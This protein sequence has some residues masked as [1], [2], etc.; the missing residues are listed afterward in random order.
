MKEEKYLEFTRKRGEVS[1]CFKLVNNVFKWKMVYLDLYECWP[2][3][4]KTRI[5]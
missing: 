5:S 1:N 3:Y 2:K 4:E